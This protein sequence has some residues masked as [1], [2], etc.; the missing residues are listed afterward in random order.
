MNSQQLPSYQQGNRSS[1]TPT[2]GYYDSDLPMS[3]GNN[4]LSPN[5]S[6]SGAEMTATNTDSSLPSEV[7]SIATGIGGTIANTAAS[8]AL[9]NLPG[10]GVASS[11]VNAAIQGGDLASIQGAVIGSLVGQVTG[12]GLS[13]LGL[14]S[15]AGLGS[16]VTSAVAS[17]AT[18]SN[19]N[20]AAAAV[21][22]LSGFG[23]RAV[24]A[25]LGGPFG[26]VVAGVL[27]D[28]A[29]ES[30]LKDGYLG[31]MTNA[32][33]SETARDAV[34]SEMGLSPSD[35]AMMADADS[36]LGGPISSTSGYGFGLSDNY[37]A[38]K[39]GFFAEQAEKAFS[40][41][42]DLMGYLN[43][44]NAEVEEGF[45]AILG[46]EDGNMASTVAS[47]E[48]AKSDQNVGRTSEATD[49]GGK[50]YGGLGATVGVTDGSPFG[51]A[52]VSNPGLGLGLAEGEN[53][54]G[55]SSGSSS[56]GNGTTGSVGSD[57]TGHNG[58]GGTAAGW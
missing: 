10:Y 4:G 22:A 57:G 49:A 23:S 31:D 26:S 37:S 41:K 11:G 53:S 6:T 1:W 18:K 24:G 3:S 50:G 34:E 55:G 15:I 38:T 12:L 17:D 16:A 9:G 5:A 14:G 27:G 56:S 25:L 45:T 48:T 32:R 28:M 42:A 40:E 43:Q 20:P 21:A 39:D 30:S 44:I 54:I 46:E 51:S 47:S 36:I 13:S 58:E 52:T 29:T 8:H 33:S 35:T 7:N 19:S 2:A